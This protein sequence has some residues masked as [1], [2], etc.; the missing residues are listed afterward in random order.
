MD[1]ARGDA[2]AGLFLWGIGACALPAA[3][4]GALWGTLDCEIPA[5][6]EHTA[7]DM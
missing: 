6:P 2:G 4:S 3:V 7:Y 5:P 1:S